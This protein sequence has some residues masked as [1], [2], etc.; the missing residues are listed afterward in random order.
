MNY[1]CD[2][3]EELTS[4]TIS[5][6]NICTSL[7]YEVQFYI[8]ALAHKK[9]HLNKFLLGTITKMNDIIDI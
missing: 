8:T 9:V 4:V 5:G 1:E 7:Y 3:N 2:F 6:V